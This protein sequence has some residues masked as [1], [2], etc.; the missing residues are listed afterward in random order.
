MLTC[1]TAGQ[2]ADD[3]C[4]ELRDGARISVVNA[5][6]YRGAI[7][8]VVLGHG[9]A[10]F[11]FKKGTSLWWKLEDESILMMDMPIETKIYELRAV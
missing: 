1:D 4:R 5:V 10:R 7:E 9:A 11:I 3:M 6:Y 8:M 2:S